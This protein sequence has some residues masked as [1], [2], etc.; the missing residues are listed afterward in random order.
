MIPMA[1]TALDRTRCARLAVKSVG[2]LADKDS[3]H[4]GDECNGHAGVS[5]AGKR[6]EGGRTHTAVQHSLRQK[7]GRLIVDISP[8]M[9]FSEAEADHPAPGDYELIE[10]Q[11]GLCNS[12][13]VF[14]LPEAQDL[15]NDS[16]LDIGAFMGST[17]W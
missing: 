3:C 5:S 17:R 9:A 4:F 2:E 7:C 13:D 14:A 8:A 10:D 1:I 6:R 12:V 16:G 15:V 11:V